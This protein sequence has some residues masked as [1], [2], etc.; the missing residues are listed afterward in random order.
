[1]IV[2]KNGRQSTLLCLPVVFIPLRPLPSS[3]FCIKSGRVDSCS[4]VALVF[5]NLGRYRS[6]AL[7]KP[8]DFTTEMTGRLMAFAVIFQFRILLAADVLSVRT[9]RMEVAAGGRIDR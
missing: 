1:M 4:G 5:I 2:K 7:T 9:A 6:G 8:T 3:V